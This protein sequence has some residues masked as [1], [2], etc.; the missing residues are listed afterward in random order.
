MSVIKN[1]LWTI[2][3]RENL[4]F[5]P[6]KKRVFFPYPT[7]SEHISSKTLFITYISP[8]KLD[9]STGYGNIRDE[10]EKSG[11]SK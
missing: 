1:N 11:N 7:R 6:H 5:P 2:K 8:Q 9:L 4:L 10:C 3:V